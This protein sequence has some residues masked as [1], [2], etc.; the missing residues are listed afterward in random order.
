MLNIQPL[1]AV[2]DLGTNTFHLLIVSGEVGGA[3][4][5]EVYR[6]R[7]FVKLAEDGIEQIGAVP[8]GRGLAALIHFAQVLRDNGLQPA[9]ARAIGTAALRTAANGPEFVERAAAEAGINIELISGDEEARL[10]TLGV[11]RAVPFGSER[12]LLMDIGGGSVEFIIADDKEVFWAR[13]FPIG[14]SVLYRDFHQTEPIAPAEVE[15]LTEFLTTVLVPLREQLASHPAHHLIGAAGTFDVIAEVMGTERLTPH[16]GNVDLSG[17]L[18]F[19]EQ[20]V[21][22]DREQRAAI[23][24]VPVERVDMIVVASILIR[25]VL[26]LAGIERLTVS[27][28]SLKEGVL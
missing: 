28:Y 7:Q 21:A 8:F 15:R 23:P 27:D 11:R 6:E 17:F 3:D 13:S 24:A 14:V 10:I 18:E 1:K 16:A 2:I 5:R 26:E 4:Y 12:V 19:H 25:V 9:A 20:L 22:S